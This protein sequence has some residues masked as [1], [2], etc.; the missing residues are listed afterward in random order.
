MSQKAKSLTA[1]ELGDM[2]I[3]S[4]WTTTYGLAQ[5]GNEPAL[6]DD[7]QPS[8]SGAPATVIP[9]AP[10]KVP[11]ESADVKTPSIRK[12]SILS[13]L[14]SVAAALKNTDVGLARR[15]LKAS[16]SVKE[17]WENHTTATLELAGDDDANDD[18]QDKGHGVLEFYGTDKAR[19][20]S[21]RNDAP[22][23][24][25]ASSRRACGSPD[26]H[27]AF[28]ELQ[29]STETPKEA[30]VETKTAAV[31]DDPD[32]VVIDPRKGFAV[33]GSEPVEASSDEDVLAGILSSR[34]RS[35]V[36]GERIEI[37]RP[38]KMP[39]Q[40]HKVWQAAATHVIKAGKIRTASGAVNY[41]EIVKVFG[42]LAGGLTVQDPEQEADGAAATTLPGPPMKDMT[43]PDDV[44]TPKIRE[45]GRKASSGRK[46]SNKT[47]WNLLRSEL[48]AA[49]KIGGNWND[50]EYSIK[51][52]D[53]GKTV[54]LVGEARPETGMAITAGT[55]GFNCIHD[56]TNGRFATVEISDGVLHNRRTEVTVRRRDIPRF[57]SS[58]ARN[59]AAAAKGIL[60]T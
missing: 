18:D 26:D 7:Q 6:D 9:G 42:R 60:S 29:A 21:L 51:S 2:G 25:T 47:A 55:V 1:S 40:F 13:E 33:V 56:S 5:A 37:N 54:E 49:S 41:P 14:R 12:A 52:S 57:A 46:A 34:K 20:T 48:V 53:Y 24:F 17:G 22:R 19:P 35:P 45:A 32:S 58:W 3:P 16:E 43:Q 50:G 27:P 31:S 30:T 11:M 23:E 8:G 4:D 36:A 10:L 15:V 44:K 28:E 59:I 39:K 38:A